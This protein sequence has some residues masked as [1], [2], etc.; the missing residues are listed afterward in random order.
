VASS[1]QVRPVIPQ[2]LD[3]IEFIGGRELYQFGQ[4]RPPGNT[5]IKFGIISIELLE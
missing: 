5:G 1:G 3:F 2:R 4:F